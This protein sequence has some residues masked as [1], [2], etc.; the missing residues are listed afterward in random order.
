MSARNIGGVNYSSVGDGGGT[1]EAASSIHRTSVS[2]SGQSIDANAAVI[3][4]TQPTA[5]VVTQ[6]QTPATVTTTIDL[7]PGNRA[8][9]QSL[10][11][12]GNQLRAEDQRI[13]AAQ[14]ANRRTPVTAVINEYDQP[15]MYSS[16]QTRSGDMQ[17]VYPTVIAISI[18]ITFILVMVANMKTYI[19]VLI[20]ILLLIIIITYFLQLKNIDI[21]QYFNRKMY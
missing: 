15:V 17:F 1:N 2:S 3:R 9:L 5:Q 7:S 18:I 20:I 13:A 10:D 12:Y 4:Q 6:H 14:Q 16:S 8:T 19:K 11:N 21:S